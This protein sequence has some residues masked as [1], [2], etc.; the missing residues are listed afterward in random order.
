MKA[1]MSREESKSHTRTDLLEAGAELLK[2][3]PVGDVTAQ[4]RAQDVVRYA[5]VSTGAFYYHWQSQYDYIKDLLDHVLSPDRYKLL[6]N[7]T[8]KKAEKHACDGDDVETAVREA[9][10]ANFEGLVHDPYHGLTLA[11][12]GR[13]KEDERIRDRVKH[14]VQE[15]NERYIPFYNE[16]LERFG[17]KMREGYTVEQL[18]TALAALAEGLV[19]RYAHDDDA[20]VGAGGDLFGTAAIQLVRGMTE[21]ADRQAGGQEAE[22]SG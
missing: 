15:R 17:L 22:P 21:P 18:Q 11:L 19:I 9:C 10:K 5:G 3:R 8:M 13:A 20:E 4:V 1:G 7:E 16:M 2:D 14:L 12:W 6:L